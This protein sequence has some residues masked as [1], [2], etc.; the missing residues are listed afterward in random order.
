LNR[1]LHLCPIGIGYDTLGGVR[2]ELRN[3][4]ERQPSLSMN[5]MATLACSSVVAATRSHTDL[6]PGHQIDGAFPSITRYLGIPVH[7]TLHLIHSLDSVL[8]HSIVVVQTPLLGTFRQR[9]ASRLHEELVK[10]MDTHF[11]NELVAIVIENTHQ[12]PS[13]FTCMVSFSAIGTIGNRKYNWC[14]S[15]NSVTIDGA[16]F[17]LNIVLFAFALFI[18]RIMS[19]DDCQVMNHIN[20][21]D[22][23]GLQ[24]IRNQLNKLDATRCVTSLIFGLPFQT[25]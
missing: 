16:S 17:S 25:L 21:A 12:C 7:I 10:F 23:N 15:T 11:L 5:D 2:N 19:L 22:N 3:A 9:T 24:A 4:I 14:Q 6:T 1:L 8:V 18:D 13:F 20:E